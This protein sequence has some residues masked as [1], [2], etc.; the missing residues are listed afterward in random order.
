M[1]PCRNPFSIARLTRSTEMAPIG[2]A[3]PY[4][5]TMP[6]TRALIN[7]LTAGIIPLRINPSSDLG[8]F[9]I[10]SKDMPPPEEGT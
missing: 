1:R 7:L 4:P 6:S 3:M 5:A 8:K 10:W 9:N 2:M